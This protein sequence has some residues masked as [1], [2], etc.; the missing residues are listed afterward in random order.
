MD[1]EKQEAQALSK[2]DLLRMLDEGRPANLSRSPKDT[3]QRAKRVVDAVIDRTE[4]PELR[5][6]LTFDRDP[7]KW[8]PISDFT[9]KEVQRI[10]TA[11]HSVR[12]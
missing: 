5:V 6:M 3:S 12:P 4:R 7:S 9:P 11:V 1:K 8:R 10:E 2:D